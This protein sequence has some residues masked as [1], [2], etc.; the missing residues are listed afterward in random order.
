MSVDESRRPPDAVPASQYVAG[1][2][3]A[4]AVF[5]AIVGI[6]GVCWLAGMIIAVALERPVF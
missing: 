2:L 1:F 6:A 3:A 5:A 4:L